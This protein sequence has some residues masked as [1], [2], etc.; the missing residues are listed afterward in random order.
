MNSLDGEICL[1]YKAVCRGF[2]LNSQKVLQAFADSLSVP[3]YLAPDTDSASY[4]ATKVFSTFIKSYPPAF[5]LNPMKRMRG[6]RH[7][8]CLVKVIK[9]FQSDEAKEKA[10]EHLCNQWFIANGVQGEGR[11]LC[12]KERLFINQPKGALLLCDLFRCCVKDVLHYFI[13]EVVIQMEQPYMNGHACQFLLHCA[14]KLH[15]IKYN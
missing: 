14:A 15:P 7:L 4:L 12:L 9:S 3:H 8:R 6:I 1:T 11:M 13:E 2:Q 10:C 5:C